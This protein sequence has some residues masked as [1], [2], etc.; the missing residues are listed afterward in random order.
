MTGFAL[1]PQAY[2][3]LWFV[4]L[5]GVLAVLGAILLHR[6]RVGQLRRDAAKLEA[7][8]AERTR[9]LS[10]AK[11]D[12][13]NATLA[14]SQFLA[15]MSHEIRTPM[16]GVIGMTGLLLET[17]L[18]RAQRD[19]AETIRASAESL[20]TVL[21]DIL[22]FSK[23]EAGKLDIEDIELNVRAQVEDVASIL[24]FQAAAK[25]I[26]LVVNVRANVP[27]RVRGDPQRIRQCLL[28]LVG[29]AIKFTQQGEVVIDVAAVGKAGDRTLLHFEVRDT[30]IGIATEVLDKLFR[31]F[32]QADASTTRKFGGSGLGLSIVRKLVD[33]MGG[34]SGAQSEAGRG[35]TF[36]FTLPMPVAAAQEEPPAAL[37]Q[38][39]AHGRRVLLVD[40][41]DTNRRVL[42]GQMVQA[43]YEVETAADPYLAEQLLR[44]A[45]APFDAV[46]LDLQMPGM[47]G[48]M[49]G[50]RIMKAPDITPTRLILLTSLDRPGDI[51]RF[52]EIGF[53]A[54]LTK[55][56]RTAELLD[57]L[58]R[59]MSQEPHVWHMRSQPIITRGSLVA[60]E[61]KK[62]YQGHVLLVEDNVV[63]QRV[64]SK[65]LERL[66][67]DV[68]VVSDGKQALQAFSH[69]AFDFILMDMQM[70][71]MDGLEATRQIRAL[72]SRNAR[73]GRTPI[74]A[75]TA[76]AMMGTLERCLAAGMD[77]Y[78]TKPLD[79]AR[80]QA[81]LGQFLAPVKTTVT[82]TAASAQDLGTQD[83]EVQ[84]ILARLASIAGDDDPGFIAELVDTYVSSCE[85]VLAEMRRAGSANDCAR[86]AAAAHK[87]RGASVNLRIDR[88]A[89]LALQ[90]ELAARAEECGNGKGLHEV[91][92][93]AAE[94]N[95]LGAALRSRLAAGPAPRQVAA[96]G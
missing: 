8:V 70:P 49:L 73:F 46:L 76:D 35:S 39:V 7:L 42:S 27:A 28:N 56:V 24:A 67:C 74:V 87:F 44:G 20:L 50:E 89:V 96:Q 72:E 16:N 12:A 82:A 66:G 86:L 32:T 13:E 88:L 60:G 14:K 68:R 31:P 19:Y 36:W 57:C 9:A 63:N 21:N 34:R 2:H 80:L 11:E 26:E 81:V 94:F 1:T 64:A 54:Y 18:D 84:E 43:G 38:N 59:A 69:A 5:C 45:S 33:M 92:R 3:V 40:D 90:I 37:S 61:Q 23:I 62:L 47:D 58:S 48:A 4:M 78:L 55:P 41:N 10:I 17:K 52:A 51:L 79:I 25:D 93:L 77:D 83:L 15:N 75:L 22:D 29:N 65:Y 91:E 30:G 95:R 85:P 71:V 53:S 6:L